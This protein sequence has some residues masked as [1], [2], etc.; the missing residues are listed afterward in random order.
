M[1]GTLFR[2][3][4]SELNSKKQ[5]KRALTLYENELIK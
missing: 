4:F 5:Q 3:R 1:T 2:E